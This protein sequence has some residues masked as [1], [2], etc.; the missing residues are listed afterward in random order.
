MGY[1]YHST[2]QKGLFGILENEK[3]LECEYNGE[4]GVFLTEDIEHA[5]MFG[6]AT[7]HIPKD[8]VDESKL[9]QDDTNDGI[10]HSGALDVSGCEVTFDDCDLFQYETYKEIVGE[11]TKQDYSKLNLNK[12]V[13]FSATPIKF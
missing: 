11:I 3:K 9:S 10:F 8:K 2:N 5:K 1:Y 7:I 4:K 12:L 13:R 6:Y